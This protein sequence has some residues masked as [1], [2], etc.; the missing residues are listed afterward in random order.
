MRV[1]ATIPEIV[2]ST[3]PSIAAA[4]EDATPPVAIAAGRPA[5]EPR[6]A[7]GRRLRRTSRPRFP[8]VSAAVLAMITAVIWSLVAAREAGKPAARPPDVRL[9]AEPGIGPRAAGAVR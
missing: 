6:R 1:L 9:A 5:I 7:D 2:G 4:V 8:L 3:A